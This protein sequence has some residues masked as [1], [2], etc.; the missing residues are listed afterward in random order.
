VEK[1]AAIQEIVQPA[2]KHT[3][4]IAYNAQ[5]PILRSAI[6][7]LQQPPQTIAINTKAIIA[8]QQQALLSQQNLF[9]EE[10]QKRTL[11]LAELQ[12]ALDRMQQ[13]QLA[14]D[15]ENARMAKEL[16]D[17]KFELY[18]LLR[19]ESYVNPKEEQ[20]NLAAASF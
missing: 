1:I 20:S 18:T 15:T 14:K 12:G 10:L 17:L 4:S 3:P 9:K 6:N 2:V 13:A 5:E 7:A 8:E 19:I 16:E 11:A